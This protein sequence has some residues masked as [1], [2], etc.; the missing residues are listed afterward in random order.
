MCGCINKQAKLFDSYGILIIYNWEELGRNLMFRDI[1]DR[2]IM[3]KMCD[4]LSV[5]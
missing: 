2:K 5:Q 1:V 4:I 3:V